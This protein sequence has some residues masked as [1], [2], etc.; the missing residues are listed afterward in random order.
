MGHVSSQGVSNAK[1]RGELPPRGIPNTKFCDNIVR[2]RLIENRVTEKT[3]FC[4]HFG[5]LEGID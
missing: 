2:P 3:I 1:I 4:R 5:T